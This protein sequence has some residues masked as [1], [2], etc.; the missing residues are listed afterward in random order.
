MFLVGVWRSSWGMFSLSYLYSP[1]CGLYQYF[2]PRKR[3][4][5]NWRFPGQTGYVDTGMSP[6]WMLLQRRMVEVV[7]TTGAIRL[8]K[9]QSNTITSQCKTLAEIDMGLNFPGFTLTGPCLD[10]V[11]CLGILSSVMYYFGYLLSI[12][13]ARATTRLN[14]C[15]LDWPAYRPWYESWHVRES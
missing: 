12:A 14:T 6:V 9:L 1:F 8:V 3:H 5:F 13:I 15:S 4:S 2:P 11:Q 7:V 10:H